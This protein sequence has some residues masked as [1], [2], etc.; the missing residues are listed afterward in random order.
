MRASVTGAGGPEKQHSTDHRIG[1]LCT[2]VSIYT[3]IF[4]SSI[5]S[6]TILFYNKIEPNT[7][8]IKILSRIRE[9]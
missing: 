1:I 4:N 3:K 9:E 6:F 5:I 8:D 2:A 7:K